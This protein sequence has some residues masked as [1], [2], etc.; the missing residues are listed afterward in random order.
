MNQNKQE[1]FSIDWSNGKDK[2][3]I[4][5]THQDGSIQMFIPEEELSQTRQEAVE[6]ERAESAKRIYKYSLESR[7][8]F[9]YREGS[10]DYRKGYDRGITQAI[11]RASN[12]ELL[13]E[14][15]SSSE[16]GEK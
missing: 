14:S 7:T 1:Q 13:E 12:G 4:C 10:Q 6:E 2:T 5:L 16:K 11:G 15:L 8:R 9:S 3:R